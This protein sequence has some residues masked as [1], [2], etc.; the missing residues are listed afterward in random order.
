MRHFEEG[1]GLNENVPAGSHVCGLGPLVC[2][3]GE[4]VSLGVGFEVSLLVSLSLMVVDQDVNSQLFICSTII[5]SKPLKLKLKP[6]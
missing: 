6:N 3:V 2:P 5:D 4:D 1:C